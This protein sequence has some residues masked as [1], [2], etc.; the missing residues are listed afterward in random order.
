MDVALSQSEESCRCCLKS[1]N[2]V[3]I[4]DEYINEDVEIAK[5]IMILIPAVPQITRNDGYSQTICIE[6]K[7]DLQAFYN[8]REM[9]I[10]TDENI[11]SSRRPTSRNNEHDYSTLTDDYVDDMDLSQYLINST[12]NHIDPDLKYDAEQ[13]TVE[14]HIEEQPTETPIFDE[15]QN[16]DA[17]P[18][19]VPKRYACPICHKLW[20]SPSKLKR[21]MTVH[22][23]KPS[24]TK[25]KQI[26]SQIQSAAI[27]K[28]TEA[29]ESK[30]KILTELKSLEVKQEPMDEMSCT[31]FICLLCGIEVPTQIRLQNHMRVQH[32]T[33][34][35]NDIDNT[36]K[37]SLLKKN[38]L[39]KHTRE[40]VVELNCYECNKSFQN[41]TKLKRHMKSHDTNKKCKPRPRRHECQQ[42]GKMFETPS[43]LLRHQSVHRKRNNNDNETTLEIS[44]V[45]SILGD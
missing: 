9:C 45:T 12:L 8:F 17:S 1:G 22:N 37:N 7:H 42:C 4:F 10:T 16:F 31:N 11:R 3:P 44:T 25:I 14:P 28:R 13:L 18:R 23:K 27:K 41:A 21:H 36:T 20:V 26:Q 19:Y 40:P 30:T 39:K 2:L 29:I 43:K 33:I 35:F 24:M 6:C 38:E 5:A 15:T 32:G 34:E